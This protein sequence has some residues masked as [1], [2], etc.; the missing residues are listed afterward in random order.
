[1]DNRQVTPMSQVGISADDVHE[2]RREKR[3]LLASS[4]LLLPLSALAG[5]AAGLIAFRTTPATYPYSLPLAVASTAFGTRS[6]KQFFAVMIGASAG[7]LM[8]ALL[9]ILNPTQQ[10]PAVSDSGDVSYYAVFARQVPS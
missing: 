3:R 8:A 7:L 6:R 1:M 5:F 9:A 4:W 10:N 2:L